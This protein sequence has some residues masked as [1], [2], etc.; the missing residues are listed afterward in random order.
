[1]NPITPGI[2]GVC[3][4]TRIWTEVKPSRP[5]DNYCEI[6]LAISDQT[7]MKHAICK[8]CLSRLTDNKIEGVFDRIKAT[9]K[10]EMVGWASDKQFDRVNG[11]KVVGWNHG[12]EVDI[13]K[14]IKEYKEK[15]HKEKI[16]IKK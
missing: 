5:N 11:L 3:E 14:K 1:M 7:K 8:F 4:E 12:D 2:C 6:Y 16:K 15:E 13:E 10:M 9:W